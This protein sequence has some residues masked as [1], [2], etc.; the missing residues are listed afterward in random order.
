LEKSENIVDF[1]IE[2]VEEGIVR[3]DVPKLDDLIEPCLQCNRSRAPVFYNPVMEFNRDIA[4]LALQ[5]YQREVRREITICEPL[6]G[7]GIRGLRYA[8]EIKGVKEVVINDISVRAFRLAHHNVKRNR[9]IGRVVTLN[10]DA[11][12][13]LNSHSRSRTRFDA[14]DVD[15]FGSPVRYL[16]SALR[17]IRNGG[18]LALTA[19]DMAALCG[20]HPKACARRYGGRPLRTEYCHEIAIRLLLGCVAMTASKYDLEVNV[21]FSYKADHYIRTFFTLEYG[22]KKANGNMD[23]MGYIRHCFSCL[24]RVLH[25]SLFDPSLLTK[26]DECGSPVHSA[27]PLWLGTLTDADFCKRVEEE[28]ASK[29]FRYGQRIR[30]LLITIKGETDAPP[31]YYVL[32][33]ICAKLGLRVPSIQRVTRALKQSGFQAA[34]THFNS[35]GIKS[36][37]SVRDMK[38]IMNHVTSTTS[39][40]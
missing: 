27:G 23:K 36:D 12:F 7:C 11:N 26:C 4:V 37:A 5:A 25:R 14:I 24:H 8:A 3:V 16:D 22:A 39:F 6:T 31:T 34:P 19:T 18:L 20:V 32:D 2:S 15:P 33:R 1:P 38:A 21:R 30:Q 13:L 10:Q 17:A 35:R 40:K 29:A 28:T 9:L